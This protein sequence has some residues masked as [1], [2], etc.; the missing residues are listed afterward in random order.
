[1]PNA[2]EI[3]GLSRTFRGNVAAVREINLVVPLGCVFGLCGPTGAGRSTLLGMLYGTIRPTTG[4]ATLL[5][6]PIGDKRLRR[7]A[8][9]LPENFPLTGRLTISAYL[10]RCGKQAGMD[11]AARQTRIA[12]L[13]AQMD[14]TDSANVRL[15]EL[16]RGMQGR[17]GLA[18]AVLHR[19]RLLILDEPDAALDLHGKEILRGLLAET[20]NAGGTVLLS[21]NSFSELEASCD[22]IAMMK[23]GQIAAQ[24]TFAELL[25]LQTTVEIEVRNLNDAA[26]NAIRTIAAKLK[27]GRMPLTK[28]TAYV[29]ENGD[30][31][32]LARAIV[33][34]GAELIALVP[35]RETL[36]EY[37]VRVTESG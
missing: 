37:F 27:L 1:M 17:V 21:S 30:I 34:N 16:S 5:D 11:A 18:Q 7:E 32:L 25:P 24:G 8:G 23:H 35:K 28:F 12:E 3:Q 20:K 26:L 13:L 4:T 9:F 33:E 29:R 10:H 22:R 2:M 14:L 31:P 15:H 19:P 36:A 6:R